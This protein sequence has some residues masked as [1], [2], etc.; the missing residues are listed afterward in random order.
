MENIIEVKNLTKIYNNKIVLNRINLKIKAGEIVSIVGPS[1]IGKTT[2]LK[3]MNNLIKIDSGKI[4]FEGVNINEIKATKLRQNIGL[5]FQEY[6]LFENMTVI[7][8]LII[9]LRHIKNMSKEESIEKARKMLN[10]FGLIEKENSYSDELSGGEKQRIAIIRTLLLDPKVI[11]FDEPTSALDKKSKLEILNIIKELS[12]N[13]ITIV[14]VSH[15][16]QFV[17]KISER[18]I[19][20]N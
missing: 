6:S 20:I 8:N 18:I 5:V 7:E 2:L 10:K 17:K 12:K 16:E 19:K 4:L 1:G 3:C 11:L 9:A 14:I 15:E 13:N